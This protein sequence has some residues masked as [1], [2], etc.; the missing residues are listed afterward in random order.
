MHA[1][2]LKVPLP[3]T[4]VAFILALRLALVHVFCLHISRWPSCFGQCTKFISLLAENLLQLNLIC[5]DQLQATIAHRGSRLFER[6]H[7][8][9]LQRLSRTLLML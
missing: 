2:I 9:I 7:C 4:I 3:L 8:Q 5:R 6:T 1:N